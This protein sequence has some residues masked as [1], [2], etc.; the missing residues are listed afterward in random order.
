[1]L[2]IE[3]MLTVI[4]P[5]DSTVKSVPPGRRGVAE[6]QGMDAPKWRNLVRIS[7]TFD[8][9]R[10]SDLSSAFGAPLF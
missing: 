5:T 3:L 1:M 4:L 10:Y 9:Y 8:S 2:G 7:P 6:G